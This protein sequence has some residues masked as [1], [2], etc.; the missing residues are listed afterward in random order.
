MS[1]DL[2]DIQVQLTERDSF[3][4][5]NGTRPGRLVPGT[6]GLVNCYRFQMTSEDIQACDPSA[7]A[8]TRHM[9]ESQGLIMALI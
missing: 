2:R 9:Y 6:A 4:T 5:R 1:E 8:L 3:C 7:V